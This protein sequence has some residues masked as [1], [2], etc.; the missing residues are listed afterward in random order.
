MRRASNRCRS[1]WSRCRRSAGSVASRRSSRRSGRHRTRRCRRRMRRASSRCRSV[2]RRCRRWVGSRRRAGGA[3]EAGV[4]ER[5]DAAV[6]RDEP[7]PVPR[8]RRA[9][10]DDRA[11]QD[12]GAAEPWGGRGRGGTAA[13]QQRADER[14]QLVDT[15]AP[16]RRRESTLLSGC[17][18]VDCGNATVDWPRADRSGPSA[19]TLVNH[20]ARR[21]RLRPATD[22]D[23]RNRDRIPR[24]RCTAW[25]ERHVN[26]E[27]GV[28]VPASSR[29]ATAPTANASMRCSRT[30]G[31]PNSSIRRCISPERTGRRRPRA[32]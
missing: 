21:P 11:V 30:S 5:E 17:G 7:V 23:G 32:W 10:V 24:P 22:R 28:G 20:P 31:R 12:H 16:H 2:W 26:L 9:D 25:L 6:G 27:T 15:K 1:G 14:E 29:R 19:I 8:R 18:R 3:E 4:T 13:E